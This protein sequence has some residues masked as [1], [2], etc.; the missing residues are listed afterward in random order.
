SFWADG[1]FVESVGKI[2]EDTIRN[3]VR[4]Q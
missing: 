3:Y 1:Y 4:N 2:T